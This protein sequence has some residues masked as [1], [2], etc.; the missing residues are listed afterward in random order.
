MIVYVFYLCLYVLYLCL[1]VFIPWYCYILKYHSWLEAYLKAQSDCR[2]I[3]ILDMV[4]TGKIQR[5]TGF[6]V[7]VFDPS[8]VWLNG[9]AEKWLTVGQ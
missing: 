1:Y 9:S 4:K 3:G 6:Q 5:A 8:A 7:H 2:K